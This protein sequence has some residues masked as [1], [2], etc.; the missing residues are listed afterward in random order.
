MEGLSKDWRP[1]LSDDE[2]GNI[3]WDAYKVSS[4]PELGG[5]AVRDH[6]ESLRQSG[7]LRDGTPLVAV[8]ANAL[9]ILKDGGK[10]YMFDMGDK[11]ALLLFD[12]SGKKH[13]IHTLMDGFPV[14]KLV[15]G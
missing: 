15:L 2:A 9:R 8:Q 6:Y 1:L 5:I 11:I 3:A 12:S 7:A 4:S 14:Y 10:Q 13:D